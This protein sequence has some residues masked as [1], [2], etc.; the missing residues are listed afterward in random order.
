MTERTLVL[1]KPDGV[2][3]SMIG[4]VITRLEKKG[5]KPVGMKLM[6]VDRTLAETHY[7]EHKGKAFFQDLVTYITS[8][9]IVAMVWEGEGAIAAVR[10]LTGA[11]DPAK[12]SP[13]TI[14]GDLALNIGH[15]LVHASDSEASAARE[16]GLFF[17]P[18]EIVEYQREADKWI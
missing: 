14:R 2:M 1:V 10:S 3:R 11:T 9:P 7:A 15:N 4:E 5:L 13:G 12:A 17:A 18:E 16:I 6:Y 8:G